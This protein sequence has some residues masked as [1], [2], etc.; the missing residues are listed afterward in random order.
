VPKD[1]PPASGD[2]IVARQLREAAMSEKDP[3]LRA[4][5]WNE[6]RRYKGLPVKPEPEDE[7]GEGE[8]AAEPEDEPADDA[9]GEA[10]E[11]SA[12]DDPAG[13]APASGRALR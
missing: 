8:T 4:K 7:A 12:E 10:D 5:L 6:Y 9:G 11:G 13:A 2:D 1:I 3:K